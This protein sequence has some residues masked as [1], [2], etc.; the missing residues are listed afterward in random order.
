MFYS[1]FLV[2]GKIHE[3]LAKLLVRDSGTSNMGGELGPL[4]P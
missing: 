1:N 3:K 4:R 2:P